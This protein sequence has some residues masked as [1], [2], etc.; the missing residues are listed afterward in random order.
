MKKAKK[1]KHLKDLIFLKIKQFSKMHKTYRMLLY[2][3]I[4]HLITEFH[5]IKI[6]NNIKHTKVEF[7]IKLIK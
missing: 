3:L 5:Q 2:K 7:N 1:K 6:N 4:N